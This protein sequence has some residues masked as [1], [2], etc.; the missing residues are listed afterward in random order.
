MTDSVDA[1]P[2]R[3]SLRPV[4]DDLT[5]FNGAILWT[6]LGT[7]F[8][9]LG[10]LR[11]RRWV[12]G[13]IALLGFLGVVGG[14]GYVLLKDRASVAHIVNQPELLI[15]TATVCG[16]FAVIM[17]GIVLATYL[18]LRP[19]TV[20]VGERVLGSFVVLVL[21]FGACAPL[22]LGAELAFAMAVHLG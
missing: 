10:L 16:M 17:V 9:G 5:T 11:A 12:T 4:N 8:P 2:R 15:L 22:A 6:L 20:T 19:R 21:A 7:I 1:G 3:A 13:A 18:A 14:L